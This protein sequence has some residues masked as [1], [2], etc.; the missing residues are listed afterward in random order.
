[1]ITAE[2]KN[3]K[4]VQQQFGLDMAKIISKQLGKL[5]QGPIEEHLTVPC[6]NNSEAI[7]LFEHIGISI[8]GDDIKLFYEYTGTAN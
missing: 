3:W 7:A 4:E 2:I 1:M 8:N 6:S 5:C